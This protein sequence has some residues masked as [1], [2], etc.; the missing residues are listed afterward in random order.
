M[1]DK[2][3]V[4]LGV[5]RNCAADLGAVLANIQRISELFADQAFI[6]VENDSKDATKTILQSWCVDRK[7]A[8]TIS[9]DG[10]VAQTPMRTVR[11]AHCRNTLM[12]IAKTEFPD[13]DYALMIDCDNINS[14]E[15]DLAAV[16][17]ALGFLEEAAGCA[18]VF[19]NSAGV[20]YDLWALRHPTL[21]PGDI[22]EGIADYV[23]SNKVSDQYAFDQFFKPRI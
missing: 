11:L 21:C 5:A 3:A 2:K 15:M 16:R 8:R 14:N 17:R 18:G 4:F 13:F 19:A 1:N 10:L 22:W 6:F 12:S 7:N 23:I 20:Y 9:F